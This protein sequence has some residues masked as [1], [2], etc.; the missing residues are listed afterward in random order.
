[1]TD[2]FYEICRLCTM[3]REAFNKFFFI[4]STSRQ[5]AHCWRIDLHRFVLSVSE[6]PGF[7]TPYGPTIDNGMVS[8]LLILTFAPTIRI[9][10]ISLRA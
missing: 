9:A 8:D 1:M 5:R 6:K 10:A 3:I 4:H 7:Q 2:S